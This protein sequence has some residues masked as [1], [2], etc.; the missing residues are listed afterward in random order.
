MIALAFVQVAAAPGSTG[1][2]VV[3]GKTRDM[4]KFGAVSILASVNQPD[5]LAVLVAGQDLWDASAW[6]NC[7][8]ERDSSVSWGRH[9]D[10]P[11]TYVLRYRRGAR[12]DVV[13]SATGSGQITVEILE[14]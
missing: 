13:A 9:I 8:K 3:K 5:A 2:R 10:R 1:W 4:K 6:V 12:C 11:G 14:K 7:W